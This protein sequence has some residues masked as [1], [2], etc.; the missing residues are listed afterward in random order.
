[1]QFNH[2]FI[3]VAS[4]FYIQY[5]SKKGGSVLKAIS[6]FLPLNVVLLPSFVTGISMLASTVSDTSQPT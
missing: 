6:N 4:Y 3:I 5:L 2:T 1:M